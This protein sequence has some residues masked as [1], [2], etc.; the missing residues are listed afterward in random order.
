MDKKTLISIIR[1]EIQ[2]ALSERELSK[3]ELKRRE[4]LVKK[5]KPSAKDMKKRYG[6]DW[7]SVMYAIATKQA[8][9]GSEGEP[10][11]KKDGD[12]DSK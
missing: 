1:E 9:A 4:V 3:A 2:S 12:E 8:K 10:E 5:L 6:D 7:K 11:K